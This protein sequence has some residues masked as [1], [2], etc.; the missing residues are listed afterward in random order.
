MILT[1]NGSIHY[2]GVAQAD[3]D[4]MS[5]IFDCFDGQW[6]LGIDKNDIAIF[7]KRRLERETSSFRAILKHDSFPLDRKRRACNVTHIFKVFSKNYTFTY[8]VLTL[9]FHTISGGI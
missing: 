8:F 2:V 9:A 6:N 7:M 4:R 5:G 3:L 1:E